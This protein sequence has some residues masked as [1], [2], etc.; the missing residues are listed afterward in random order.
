MSDSG[1]TKALAASML[2]SWPET[3]GFD[4]PWLQGQITRL[5][6]QTASSSTARIMA[7]ILSSRTEVILFPAR[8]SS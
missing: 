6:K 4:Y 8:E 7:S 2:S 3:L 1:L 5:S